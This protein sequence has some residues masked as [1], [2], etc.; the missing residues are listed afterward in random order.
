MRDFSQ[1]QY[2][3][4]LRDM[5]NGKNQFCRLKHVEFR[6]N[7]TARSNHVVL[8]GL[9]FEKKGGDLNVSIVEYYLHLHSMFEKSLSGSS[10]TPV[11]F[12][13]VQGV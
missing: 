12:V 13:N 6:P 4:S 7:A 9:P 8:C 11:I 2:N 1:F 10:D 5:T 3:K